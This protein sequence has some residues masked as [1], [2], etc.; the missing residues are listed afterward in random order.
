MNPVFDFFFPVSSVSIHT[1]QAQP[2]CNPTILVQVNKDCH[3]T[4]LNGYFSIFTLLDL[5]IS[6]D[7][8]DQSLILSV[9]KLF[10][11]DLHETTNL[12]FSF[13][14]SNHSFLSPLLVLLICHT[15]EL[16]DSFLIPYLFHYTKSCGYIIHS[17][18]LN[19]H[20]YA[21]DPQIYI[22]NLDISFES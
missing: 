3:V 10:F 17:Q 12:P 21:Y 5:S 2:I 1:N 14:L 11:I 20:L 6:C 18:D 9:L 4:K 7:T 8:I 15:S 22:S 13:Y 16:K 19:H